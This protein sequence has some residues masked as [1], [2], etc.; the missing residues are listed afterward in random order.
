MASPCLSVGLCHAL[1]LVLLLDGIAVGGLLGAVHDLISQAL[2][3]GL[4]VAEGTV[5]GTSANQVDGLVHATQRGHVHRLTSNDTCGSNARGILTRASILDCIHED[6]DGVLVGE[7]VDDLEGMLHNAH[8]HQLLAVVAA[9]HHHG[10]CQ[11][12]HNGAQSLAE[13]SHLVA[14]LRVGQEQVGGLVHCNVVHQ[15]EVRQHHILI[16]P[17]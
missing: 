15:A 7:Q 4:D 14:A 16:G 17:W 13:A 3:D 6:L 8:R 5:A 9:V 1:N 11:P 10:A 2:R 12:L